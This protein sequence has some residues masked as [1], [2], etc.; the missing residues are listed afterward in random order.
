[1]LA[2]AILL[3]VAVLAPAR[4]A[5][6]GG[7]AREQG[8]VFVR[9]G[10]GAFFGEP[11]FERTAGDFRGYA[12]ELYGEVGL[13]ADLEI[14][15]SFRWVSNERVFDDGRTLVNGGPEE[16]ELALK[17]AAV[18]ETNA[19][20][21]VL[22]GR[23]ALYERLDAV[24]AMMQLPERGPGGGDVIAG[25]SFGHSFHPAPLWYNLDVVHR[26]RIGSPSSGVLLRNEF[27]YKP[28][29][30]LG[31][32]ALVELGPTF[33]RDLETPAG[34]PAPVPTAFALGAKIFGEIALGFGYLLD[35]FWFP[36]VL[37]DGPGLRFGASATYRR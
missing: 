19:F 32:A 24:D 16:L 1:V 18:N 26:I 30:Q 7:W 28:L 36:D 14:D 35:F 15:A 12:F 17:W 10:F 37:N 22:G 11:A 27:G 23:I 29:E 34:A 6:A 3:V 8:G 33:G 25:F 2:R 5:H 4:Q 21:L 31:L 13:G 20:A 9:S